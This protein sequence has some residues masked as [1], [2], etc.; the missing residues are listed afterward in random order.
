VARTWATRPPP[1]S[2]KACGREGRAWRALG[3]RVLPLRRTR[4]VNGRGGRGAHLGNASSPSVEQGDGLTRGHTRS[5][6]TGSKTQDTHRH[7]GTAASHAD[8]ATPERT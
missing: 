2:N 7:E 5:R 4:R 1:P 8:A 3:Q 6:N